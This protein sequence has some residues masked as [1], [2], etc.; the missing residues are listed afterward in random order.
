MPRLSIS[1]LRPTGAALVL[2]LAALLGGCSSD[3]A[4]LPDFGQAKTPQVLAT[5]DATPFAAN[6]QVDLAIGDWYPNEKRMEINALELKSDNSGRQLSFYMNA[7]TGPGTYVIGT[8]SAG[9]SSAY[10]I[11]SPNVLASIEVRQAQDVVYVTQRANSGTVTV[12]SYDATRRWIEGTFTIEA[13]R[14]DDPTKVV[15]ITSGSFAG[16]VAPGT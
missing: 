12:T 14:L 6:Y 15:T 4:T 8:A 11:V 5:I 9:G 10:L 16:R 1:S 2:S 13:A 7:F 3:S